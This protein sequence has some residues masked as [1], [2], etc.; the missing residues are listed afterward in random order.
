MDDQ[1]DNDLRDRIKE[2]FENIDN[3]SAD[4]GWLLLR[5]KFP[6]EQSKRR[7][8]A[9]LWWGSAAAVL[10]LVA[11]LGIWVNNKHIESKKIFYKAVKHVQH[12]KQVI[13]NER[14]DTTH[15]TTPV[16][17]T[18]SLAKSSTSQ[19]KINANPLK[20]QGKTNLPVQPARIN[21]LASNNTAEKNAIIA[22]KN[23]GNVKITTNNVQAQQIAVAANPNVVTTNPNTVAA[24]SDASKTNAN[25][26]TVKPNTVTT[27]PNAVAANPGAVPADKV[28]PL[29]QPKAKSIEDMF[30]EDKSTP[31]IKNDKK[32]KNDKK[33]RFEIYEATYFNYAKGSNSQVNAGAGF[34]S[35]I[36]ISENLRLVTGVSIGQNT[37]SYTAG[38]PPTNNQSL[39]AAS[40]A[41]PS[42]TYGVAA[43]G[44]LGI[45]TINNTAAT[46]TFKDYDASL[47]GLDIPV[48]LK[49]EF[50]PEKSDTY[51]SAG[52]SSGTFINE[53]YTSQY[54][55]SSFF[56]PSSQETQAETT[57]KSFNGFYFA[58]TLNV[59]FGVGYPLGKNHLV[60]EPFLK[61]PLEGLGSQQ[62]RFG[63]GGINL[64]FNFESLKK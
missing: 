49:Y 3:T 4:E 11:G 20:E 50:N 59:A 18:N 57:T 40:F 32:L 24:I 36:K 51:I 45:A 15:K 27:N 30:A 25:T 2:V 7:G 41:R 48:N 31:A 22:K 39:D 5:K 37:L 10:L 17:N 58:K 43:P 8:F 52:L 16:T 53:S 19:Q 55:Y 35:D 60:I 28:S 61:Y 34:T 12:E 6:A 14:N 62:I 63:S 21:K 26:L 29:Q 23:A 42:F 13:G 1:L 54:N 9:W 46:T 64:K 33:V 38:P 47:V 44:S 56:S